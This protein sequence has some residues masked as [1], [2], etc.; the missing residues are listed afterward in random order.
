MVFLM[1][2]LWNS[3]KINPTESKN[4]SL[5]SDFKKEGN[6]RIYDHDR[7]T[8]PYTCIIAYYHN[9]IIIGIDQFNLCIIVI[10]ILTRAKNKLIHFLF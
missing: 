7:V 1:E 10:C 3:A 9:K 6:V 2:K 4:I 8:E 5:A